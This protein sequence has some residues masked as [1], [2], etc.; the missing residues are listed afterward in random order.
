[1]AANGVGTAPGAPLD[2]RGGVAAC[3]GSEGS[4]SSADRDDRAEG[5]AEGLAK[6]V[7]TAP[8]VGRCGRLVLGGCGGDSSSSS[9]S[10]SP[11]SAASAS[12]RSFSSSC[13]L[14][15]SYQGDI[16]NKVSAR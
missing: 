9:Y 14:S 3:V 13:L 4:S 16:D 5:M 12:R 8:C 2:E 6:G 15:R 7:A 11:C 10:F 1:M